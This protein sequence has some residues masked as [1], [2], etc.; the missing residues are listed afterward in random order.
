MD[1]A[2]NRPKARY[3]QYQCITKILSKYKAFNKKAFFTSKDHRGYKLWSS[4]NV[5]DALSYLFDNIFFRF[6]NL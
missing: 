4:Q 2:V 6:G 1:T 5:C 3:S